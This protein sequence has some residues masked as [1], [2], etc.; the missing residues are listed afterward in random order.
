LGSSDDGEFIAS[1]HR[2]D[3]Q[4]KALDLDWTIVRPSVVYS[5]RGS[6]GGTS[7]LRAMSALPAILLLPGDGQQAIEPIGA[8]DFALLIVHLLEQGSAKR[9]ILE[10][11][12]PET[13]T[14]ESYLKS[15]RRWLNLSN[16]CV[17]RVPATIVAVAAWVGEHFGGGPLGAT[18]HR[19]LARGNCAQPC[20]RDELKSA[21]EWVAKP[22]EQVLAAEPSFVQDRWHARM[23]FLVPLLR[24][25]LGLVW[26]G[27][28]IVGLATPPTQIRTI[29]AGA[30]TTSGAV[31][32]VY[33][34]S[35]VDFLLGAMLV[36]PRFVKPTGSLMLVA[37]LS[38]TLFIGFSLPAVWL[39]PFG[40]LIKNIA[41]IPAVLI[42]IATADRA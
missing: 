27:S 11:G 32:L 30:G 24:F 41:L 34:A 5:P 29:L 16:P 2:G 18:M 1:K 7:L 23:Y 10:V 25:A 38:Y 6:Y 22:L 3:D 9:R 35:V 12:G 40:G 19:L 36:V 13:L 31:A 37:L 26:I 33:G 14:L 28:A 8:A 20:H 17:F 39:E 4:L 15:W 42:M 21:V